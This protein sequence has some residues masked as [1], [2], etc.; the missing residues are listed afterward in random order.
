MSCSWEPGLLW[1]IWP[2]KV[3]LSGSGLIRWH[4]E[5][6]FCSLF[7]N[8]SRGRLRHDRAGGVTV[9]SEVGKLLRD[10]ISSA[11]VLLIHIFL[12]SFCGTAIAI[13]HQGEEEDNYR[14]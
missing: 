3:L 6:T 9:K 10:K 5:V 7:P 12:L 8:L 2:E 13:V 14:R 4:L 11:A 1:F